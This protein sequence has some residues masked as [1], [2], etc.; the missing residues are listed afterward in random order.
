MQEYTPVTI[1]PG[2]TTVATF[3]GNFGVP[4]KCLGFLQR[5]ANYLLKIV[6]TDGE[7]TSWSDSSFAPEGGKSHTGW[8]VTVGSAPVAW[9]SSRQSVVTLSTAEAELA[10]SV[11]G[12]LALSSVEALLSDLGF[13]RSQGVLMT[14]SQSA[15]AIQKG[16]CSWRTRHLKIKA[17]WITERLQQ[18]ELRIEHCPGEVQVADALTKP[19]TASRLRML[20]KLIGLLTAEEI[21]EEEEELIERERVKVCRA[22]A[23]TG[24]RTL[25]ALM[26]LS[27]AVSGCSATELVVHEP[28]S[29]D[30]GLVMW[31]LF[32]VVVLLWTV[33]WELI[34]FAGWQIYYSAMP[35]AGSRRLRRLQ[36]IRDTTTAAIQSELEQR[37]E[38][39]RQSRPR[40]EEPVQPLGGSTS[41]SSGSDRLTYR[42]SQRDR[43]IQT[44]GPSFAPPVPQVR[45]EIRI[46]E[47]VHYVPGNQCFHIYNPCHA[48][49][50]RG[51]Q[52]KV[53][54]L[55][56]CEFCMRHQGRDPTARVG[57]VDEILRSGF[58]PNYD[59]PGTAD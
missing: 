56:V 15:L 34:K 7:V 43:A 12:A 18:Q 21:Q 59:R 53:C 55:R 6:S 38:T 50:H 33:A 30:G 27:Q 26:I 14:D 28:M 42:A 39:M 36:R 23:D 1:I 52:A 16:S 4:G 9:R 45:T 20:T 58:T 24:A 13:E 44:T 35:G 37:R 54:T 2:T 17:S 3:M 48:F 5:T 19:L 57:G 29:V 40:Y 22:H 51:T 49:R 11:E 32:A 41:R 8:I 47:Q 10:A 46:P 25:I 31:C